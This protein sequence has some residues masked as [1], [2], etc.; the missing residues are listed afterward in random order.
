MPKAILALDYGTRKVG[1]AVGYRETDMAH[2]LAVIFYRNMAMLLAEI[3]KLIDEWRPDLVLIGAPSHRD[4]TPHPIAA[5][6]NLLAQKI[7]RQ[8]G[9]QTT[10]FDERLTTMAAKSCLTEMGVPA[11]QQKAVADCIAACEII[12]GYL[13]DAA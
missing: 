4:G 3:G 8:F 5:K 10:L 7:A 12:R 1:V 2:P 13:S 6:A 9:V 11:H